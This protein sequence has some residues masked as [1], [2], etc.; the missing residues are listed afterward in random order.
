M[1]N[2]FH[3]A[4]RNLVR[5]KKRS[6]LS[7]LSVF[8]G[9]IIAGLGHGYVNGIL[10]R[11]VEDYITF[12]TGHIRITTPEYLN[13]EKFFPVDELITGS[14]KLMADVKKLPLVKSVEERIRFGLLLAKDENTTDAV[15]LALDFKQNHFDLKGKLKEGQLKAGLVYPGVKLA[16]KLHVQTGD[17][18][19][20]AAR[21]SQ[22]GLNGIKL[23]IGGLVEMGVTSFDNRFF[24]LDLPSAKRLLRIYN[25]TTE[26]YVYQHDHPEVEN[27]EKQ[28]KELTSNTLAVQSYITQMGDLYSTLEGARVIYAVFVILILFLASFV[29]VN[30]MMVA[31][32]ERLKE[33]GTMKA[34]GFTDSELFWQLTL[35]GGIIG[36]IGG[37][38]GGI[39]GYLLVI[40]INYVGIDISAMGNIDM[41]IQYVIR[42]A[43]RMID[44]FIIIAMVTIVPVLASMIPAR[45]VNKLTPADALRK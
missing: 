25:S 21:T 37:I 15:G 7:V 27:T 16:K 30:T 34:I 42:P 17:D 19:L 40:L 43:I 14:D 11:Y 23:K 33:L 12:Q 22:G 2:L 5:N 28:I 45:Y 38:P 20:I 36:I 24:F 29:I 1:K 13:R 9:A 41:P 32:F 44:L 18:L 8:L 3:L 26:I 4:I 10:D 39:V 31:I 6:Y 35:E